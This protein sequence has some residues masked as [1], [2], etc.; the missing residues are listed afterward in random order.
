MAR[1]THIDDGTDKGTPGK[2]SLADPLLNVSSS[3]APLSM[4][5]YQLATNRQFEAQTQAPFQDVCQIPSSSSP[6]THRSRTA[7]SPTKLKHIHTSHIPTPHRTAPPPSD[8]GLALSPTS[9]NIQG[10][11][12][13]AGSRG[14][15]RLQ[16]ANAPTTLHD[17]RGASG[18]VPHHLD[19]CD[20]QLFLPSA[21]Q[22]SVH[23]YLPPSLASRRNLE[24]TQL[25]EEGGRR[26]YVWS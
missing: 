4:Q 7:S 22:F 8:R 3:F 20:T 16:R 19:L 24:P 17:G 2:V 21:L 11:D 14:G 1:S 13:P 12:G 25:G 6:S 15:Q 18:R 10:R 23:V 9:R 5:I 26:Y